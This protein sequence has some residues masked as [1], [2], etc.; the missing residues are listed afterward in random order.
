MRGDAGVVDQQIEAAELVAGRFERAVA[1][2]GIGYVAGDEHGSP[3][4]RINLFR[5]FGET[6]FASCKQH[7]IDAMTCELNGKR[8]TDAT[9]SA[10]NECASIGESAVRHIQ[11]EDS[12][13]ARF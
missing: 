7:E 10:G 11:M 4:Q 3:A 5:H 13:V 1:S 6:V 8:A 12:G 2:G 9:R